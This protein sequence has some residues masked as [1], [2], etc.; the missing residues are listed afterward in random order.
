MFSS[1]DSNG[2]EWRI[3]GHEMINAAKS[4]PVSEPWAPIKSIGRKSRPR[5]HELALRIDSQ[6]ACAGNR[7]SLSL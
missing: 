3:R 1:V 4:N 2:G 6:G 7:K 5:A